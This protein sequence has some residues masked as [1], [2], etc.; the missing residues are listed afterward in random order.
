MCRNSHCVTAGRQ[1]HVPEPG[2]FGTREDFKILF[3]PYGKE[4]LIWNLLKPWIPETHMKSTRFSFTRATTLIA[5]LLVLFTLT[6][7]FV[8][9]KQETET[10]YVYVYLGGASKPDSTLIGTWLDS[11][12]GKSYYE[13]SENAFKNYGE[14][15]EGVSYESYEGSDTYV[16]KTSD[17]AGYIYIK[18]TKA[19]NADF[20]SYSSDPNVAPDVGKWYAIAYKDLTSNSISISGAYGKKSST[21]TLAEAIQEF[22][23]ENGYFAFYSDCAKQ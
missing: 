21:D 6:V 11:S 3:L 16:L 15:T 14:N 18:Y 17:T 20:S 4:N 23:I 13:I 7:G 12:Y 9:C 1:K 19:A 8:S 22:T 2:N 10:E 5:S